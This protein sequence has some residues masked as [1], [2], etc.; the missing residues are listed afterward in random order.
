MKKIQAFG[1]SLIFIVFFVFQQVYS[2][3]G[4]SENINE[5][6][7][8]I[9]YAL[10]LIIGIHQFSQKNINR[11]A[12][13]F[14][15]FSALGTLGTII[16]GRPI[17]MIIL[18]FVYAI[19]GYAGYS[20]LKNHKV[21]A[22]YVGI[23]LILLY[24]VFYL[25]YFQFR[26]LNV[27]L[28]EEGDL[29]GHSSSNTIAISLNFVLW[30]YFFIDYTQESKNI[31]W[32]FILSIA[33]LVLCFIQASRMGLAASFVMFLVAYYTL[34]KHTKSRWPKYLFYLVVVLALTQVPKFA[35]FIE[36][37][38]VASNIAGFEYAEEVRAR[39]IKA[40][41]E[42]MDISHAMFGYGDDSIFQNGR[43]FNAALD[44]WDRYGLI[45]FVF[46][47]VLVVKRIINRKKYSINL[48]VYVPIL[49][50]S[51]SETIF[52]GTLWDFFLYLFLFYGYK[53]NL[54]NVLT[55]KQLKQI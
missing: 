55:R 48:Y 25:V 37:Y 46:L 33:N 19:A 7:W 1:I 22:N 4:L 53:D 20:Y 40:F 39:S 31:L 12:Q 10:L 29:F 52:G 27:E 15:I 14:M 42:N 44:F 13:T 5:R 18:F 41:F 49:L 47:I 50:Y 28:A 6:Y 36:D 23:L 24:F 38:S 54:A 51:F 16:N 2:F 26:E 30:V 45:P 8:Q 11:T 21:Q 32:V 35:G 3:V 9:V 34:A 17:G 43:T